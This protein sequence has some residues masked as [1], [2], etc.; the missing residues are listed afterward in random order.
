M[1]PPD[2]IDLAEAVSVP[3]AEAVDRDVPGAAVDEPIR[4]VNHAPESARE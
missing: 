1:P 2:P 3:T 4:I